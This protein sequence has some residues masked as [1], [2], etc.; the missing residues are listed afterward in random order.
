MEWSQKTW[1]P[2]SCISKCRFRRNRLSSSIPFYP[3]ESAALTF[4]HANP[5]VFICIARK[6]CVSNELLTFQSV[7]PW[8]NWSYVRNCGLWVVHVGSGG[9]TVTG[10]KHRIVY[11]VLTSDIA[12]SRL[13]RTQCLY[14]LRRKKHHFCNVLAVLIWPL[15][16]WSNHDGYCDYLAIIAFLLGFYILSNYATGGLVE[17]LKNIENESSMFYVRGGF[18]IWPVLPVGR[19][20]Q[21]IPLKCVPPVQHDYF[22]SFNQSRHYLVRR[23]R[24]LCLK[25][26]IINYSSPLRFFRFLLI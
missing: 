9:A 14:S 18:K 1:P 13:K 25:P 26:S 4:Q 19:L 12:H 17:V 5:I 21:R 20:L 3:V 8:S 15:V 7:S 2:Q 24:R 22:S 23:C 11:S 10:L 6:F 16:S